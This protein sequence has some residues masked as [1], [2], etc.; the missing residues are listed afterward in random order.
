MRGGGGRG[1]RARP[2]GERRGGDGDD[3][4]GEGAGAGRRGVR[5]RRGRAHPGLITTGL[6]VL[7][8]AADELPA[9]R[10]KAARGRGRR[11]R[12][13][14]LRPDRRP[15]TSTSARWSPRPPSPDYLGLA[16]LRRRQDPAPPH[17]QPRPAPL[18]VGDDRD[19][20]QDRRDDRGDH[21]EDD[22]HGDHDPLE[23]R[24]LLG[25]LLGL[26]GLARARSRAARPAQANSS[27]RI[28]S[29][30]GMT[31]SAGPGRT[32]IASPASSSVKPATTISTRRYSGRLEVD[33]RAARACA[34]PASAS[35]RRSARSSFS[36]EVA[37][38]DERA[39]AFRGVGQGGAGA[40][41][42]GDQER[43]RVDGLAAVGVD[44]EVQVRRGRLGVAG[45]ADVAEDRARLDVAVVD[46]RRAR[47]TRGARRRTGRRRRRRPTGG[48]RRS[49]ASRR[50]RSCRR[51]P[52]RRACRSRRTG[53]C[54]GGRRCRRGRSRTG[55]RSVVLPPTGKTKRLDISRF[56]QL[57]VVARGFGRRGR[58]RR[59]RR[60][61]ARRSASRW[62][63]ARLAAAPRAAPRRR[64]PRPWSR[65]GS[66]S[67]SSV[68]VT[69]S[70]A[71]P[72]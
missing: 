38:L 48:C 51:R 21:G 42:P 3:A 46:R 33:P 28:A 23:A 65:P 30:I 53:R 58:L 71:P 56:F 11:D 57:G 41:L 47:R 66:P 14:A 7:R 25:R 43:V 44:L 55:R 68:S 1:A 35:A 17:R 24:G 40:L 2:G 64:R 12:L 26:L 67:R 29:A 32:S 72:G 36:Y 20:P 37:D 45:V 69:V 54:P 15:T 31:A 4:R 9:L 16:L 61:S 13:P 52:R 22:R 63:S 18:G 34:R 8:A 49:A 19:L 70:P 5:G 6:P 27:E 39:G 50:S 10:A 60:A 59:G 62:R